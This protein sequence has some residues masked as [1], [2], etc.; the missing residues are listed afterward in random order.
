MQLSSSWTECHRGTRAFFPPFFLLTGCK[1]Q[2]VTRCWWE[3]KNSALQHNELQVKC[4]MCLAGHSCCWHHEFKSWVVLTSIQPTYCANTYCN[5]QAGKHSVTSQGLVLIP[6]PELD[7]LYTSN[8]LASTQISADFYTPNSLAQAAFC[9]MLIV[10]LKAYRT[11]ECTCGIKV[12]YWSF[13]T[14]Y[15]E[16]FKYIHNVVNDSGHMIIGFLWTQIS[17]TTQRD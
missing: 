14:W 11:A 4:W 8:F 1:F 12:A 10:I 6:G 13:Y 16:P 15:D 3:C 5:S 2:I 17:V 7:T 9:H